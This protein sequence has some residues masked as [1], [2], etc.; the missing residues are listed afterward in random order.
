[1]ARKTYEK[2][3]PEEMKARIAET[4][5]KLFREV[6]YSKTTVA[7]IAAALAMSPANVY[8]YFSSKLAINEIIC[9]RILENIES[10]CL[11]AIGDD[12]SIA[13]KIKHFILEYHRAGKDNFIKE[14]RVH[15]MVIAALEQHWPSIDRHGRR[16]LN[17]L[18]TLLQEG[19]RSGEFK[20]VDPLKAGLAI[21]NAIVGFVYPAL[22]EWSLIEAASQ[23]VPETLEED[24]DY[25]LNML[26]G[27]LRAA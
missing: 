2:A 24:L 18:Q 19:I 10:G 12:A 4:A 23:G 26:L 17:I 13:E 6:G 20:A 5:E 25:L 9:E 15:D 11:A 22:L 27:S 8:R 14:K 3:T 1:M 7:D 21:R 16:V